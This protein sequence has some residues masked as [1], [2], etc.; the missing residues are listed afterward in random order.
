MLQYEY[1]DLR[2][3]LTDRTTTE[4]YF[5]QIEDDSDI[6]F[7]SDSDKYARESRFVEEYY[8]KISEKHDLL[9]L[10]ERALFSHIPENLSKSIL[11]SFLKRLSADIDNIDE[12]THSGDAFRYPYQINPLHKFPLPQCDN[13][14][15][16]PDSVAVR[17]AFRE[18]FYYD[19]ISLPD[20]GDP[21]GNSGGAFGDT[22][23]DYLEDWVY[24]C[25]TSLLSKNCVLKNPM[26]WTKDLNEAC[27]LLVTAADTLYVIEC[28][29]GKLPQQTRTGEIEP[30]R[31][32]LENKVVKGYEDQAMDLIN[33][34]R[35]GEVD[36]VIYD[37][38]MVDISGYSE[39]RPIIVTDEPYDELATIHA[40]ELFDEVDLIPYIIKITDL[41][42]V[43]AFFEDSDELLSYIESRAEILED[44]RFRSVDEID[45]LGYYV[46]MEYAFPKPDDADEVHLDGFRNAVFPDIREKIESGGSMAD[47]NY[48]D[49]DS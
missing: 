13:R 18:T 17:R 45:Y 29:I 37:G 7:V 47:D 31:E 33:Q 35:K 11:V 34:L 12:V 48:F 23:G 46:E 28:K 32:A 26:Y 6:I 9:S 15:F 27:D 39:F 43:T 2:R 14:I 25:L 1:P 44:T 4:D 42:A 3:I 20:Y 16:L 30:I 24:D 41:Q 40:S 49:L 8:H 19:L 21:G 36:T 5:K 22:F 38:E 10:N